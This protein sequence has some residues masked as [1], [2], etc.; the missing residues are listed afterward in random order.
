VI[1]MGYLFFLEMADGKWP[2]A[3]G[4]ADHNSSQI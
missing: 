2:L 4:G 1:D 3:E